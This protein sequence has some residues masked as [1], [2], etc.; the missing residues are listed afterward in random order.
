MK[1]LPLFSRDQSSRDW[2]APLNA[3]PRVTGSSGSTPHGRSRR[4]SRHAR[5]GLRGPRVACRLPHWRSWWKGNW[6]SCPH[7]SKPYWRIKASFAAPDHTYEAW[8]FD[9]KKEQLKVDE[10]ARD[11]WILDEKKAKEIQEKVQGQ[12]GVAR[13]ARKTS[14]EKAPSPFDLTTLREKR[15]TAS[16]AIPHGVPW[17]PRKGSTK[18]TS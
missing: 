3:G 10:E 13:E 11:D 7:Q 17:M 5:N 15:D 16:S 4:D 8:W 6:R 18:I 2:G 12:A 14:K 1:G 9:P